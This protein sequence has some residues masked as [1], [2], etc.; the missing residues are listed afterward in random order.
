MERALNYTRNVAVVLL[1][2]LVVFV[3]CAAVAAVFNATTWQTVNE[4]V[5]KAVMVTG[6]L[7]V[8]NVVVALLVGSSGKKSS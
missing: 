3:A 2:G 7:F 6:I 1:A 8:G 4:W 5:S